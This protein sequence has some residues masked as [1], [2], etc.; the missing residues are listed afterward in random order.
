MN[1]RY[2]ISAA[3]MV[4]MPMAAQSQY[5]LEDCQQMAIK[6]NITLLNANNEISMA[7]EQKKEAF[8]KYFPT[9]S[10]T[11][12]GFQSNKNMVNV[13]MSGTSM[14]LLKKGLL[15]SISAIQPIFSGGQIVNNNK[16]ATVGIESSK[17]KM[18]KTV[19]DVRLNTEQYFWQ[20]VTLKEKTKT[21]KTMRVMLERLYK[22]A[23][24][25]IKAG[26]TL[27]NDLLQVQLKQND[28][29]SQLIAV[30]NSL[31]VSKMLLAQYIGSKDNEFD[32][33]QNIDRDNMPDFPMSLKQDHKSVLM[34]TPEYQLMEK[35]VESNELQRKIE[36][37]KNLPSVG[38]G[39]GYSYSDLMGTGKNQG[40][41]FATLSVPISSWWGGSHAIKKQK[42]SVINAKN[43]LQDNSEL[44]LIKMQKTWND[45][46]DAYKQLN[47]AHKSIEQSNENLRLNNVYYKAGTSKM[48]DMLDAQ[49][50][51]QQSQDK[52]VD[53]FAQYE[54][55][56]LEYKQLTNIK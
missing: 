23:D 5:S 36:I 27:K 16:L 51:Y 33:G 2:I 10:A 50:Q 54:T 13:D 20:V 14:G 1:K 35:N 9:V 18:D 39:A 49:S 21:L 43:Q 38:I 47:L 42:I 37:G 12:L 24:I 31:E 4:A 6:H 15:G 11:G 25:S 8:T 30:N 48:S 29:E 32:V 40:M 7:E 45:I 34:N 28:I 3:I 22:D 17:I 19:K 41:I 53:A 26:I 52:F 55:K 56:I 44:L 46:E